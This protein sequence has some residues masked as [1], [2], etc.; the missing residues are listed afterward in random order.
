MRGITDTKHRVF[1]AS[2]WRDTGL[3]RL[4]QEVWQAGQ[5]EIEGQRQPS[6]IWVAEFDAEELGRFD[7][8]DDLMIV[9]ACLDAIQSSDR[10]ILLDNGGYGTRLGGLRGTAASSFLELELYQAVTLQKPITVLALGASVAERS[11]LIA[12]LNDFVGPASD[13]QI[14]SGLSEAKDCI[15]RICDDGKRGTSARRH[16]RRRAALA[17]A[18]RYYPNW[19][20]RELFREPI[21]LQGAPVGDISD[22]RN[23]DLAKQYLDDADRYLGMNRIL[24]R[25][26]IAMRLMM[27]EH[28]SET[29]DPRFTALWERALNNWNKAAAWRGLHGH[30]LLGSLAAASAQA[31]M[32]QRLGGRL[33]DRDVDRDLYSALA[34][35]NYSIA[36]IMPH[37]LRRSFYRR[38]EAYVQEG[39]RKARASDRERLLPLRGA[40]EL[41]L[42]RPWDA[43]RT[44]E[45]ALRSEVRT[46]DADRIGFVMTELGWAKLWMA[47]VSGAR[48]MLDDGIGKLTES[49]G[50]GMRAR[51]LRKSM[52]ANLVGFRFDEARDRATKLIE[53]ASSADAFD[54]IDR[55]ARLLRRR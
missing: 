45:E 27:A 23:A 11:P 36:G 6:R 1:L 18:K 25:T 51:M 17:L 24:S 43:H 49:C 52:Y 46:G 7:P 39:W 3:Q 55:G 41:R 50:I 37:H 22:S 13:I 35:A 20:Q 5:R 32:V 15:F 4:R 9:D 38:A 40:I 12:L 33:Y 16:D 44:F 19:R 10:F 54:Q 53:E 8:R 30:L 29:T 26:W 31:S 2:T 14:V 42:L 28:F 47:N 48:T 21:F 34:S